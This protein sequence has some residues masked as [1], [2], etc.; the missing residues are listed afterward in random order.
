[1]NSKPKDRDAATSAGPWRQSIR[2]LVSLLLIGHITAVFMPPFAFQ[3]S[4]I[5]GLGSPLAETAMSVLAPY[6]DAVYLNHGYA[7]F[8]PDPGPSHLLRARLEYTDGRP[9]RVVTLPDRQTHWPR[10]MYHRHFMLS[11]HLN[12]SFAPPALPAEIAEDDAQVADWQFV[13]SM[14]EARRAAIAAHLLHRYDAERVTIE[15]LE[16][17]LLDP[18]EFAVLRL[19]PDAV[20]T[21]IVLPETV[22]E[23][24]RGQP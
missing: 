11:E 17:R 8:A 4:P 7:F 14:Y 24:E 23:A 2:I 13:R 3:T 6:I 18:Y 16:H 20:E 22:D 12:A 15:R 10:L 21:L 1:M 9:P 19:K 5:R